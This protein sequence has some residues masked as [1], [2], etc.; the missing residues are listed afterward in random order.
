MKSGEKKR[1]SH[2]DDQG[3]AKMVEV[4]QKSDTVREAVAHGW[5]KLSR[6][7]VQLIEGGSLKKGDALE[8]AKVAGIMAAKKTHEL[9]P[10]CHPLLLTQVEVDLTLTDAGVEIRSRVVCVGKTGV[11]MEALTAVAAAALTIYDMCKAVDKEMVI[12]D[13]FLLQKS[14][15][16]SGTYVKSSS[17]S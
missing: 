9:I 1:L 8:V 7:V 11:E 3:K 5:V 17:G 2:L 4:T 16:R 6:E 13:I 12:G 14:G 15:G 10:L